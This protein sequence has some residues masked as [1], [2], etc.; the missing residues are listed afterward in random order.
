RSRQVGRCQTRQLQAW[1]SAGLSDRDRACLRQSHRR[2]GRGCPTKRSPSGALANQPL[3][4]AFASP[5]RGTPCACM[6]LSK[7]LRLRFSFYIMHGLPTK[8][9]I[10]EVTSAID[11]WITELEGSL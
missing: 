1:S 10:E 8:E 2:P 4:R 6:K 3:D 9:K 11:V 7:R 5:P